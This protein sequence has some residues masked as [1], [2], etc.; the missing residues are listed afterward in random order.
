MICQNHLFAHQSIEESQH[1]AYDPDQPEGNKLPSPTNTER[2]ERALYAL[3]V[4]AELIYGEHRYSNADA[5]TVISDY[6]GDL[7]HL[8]RMNGLH[9]E[10][11]VARARIRHNE[12]CQGD[13]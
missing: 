10:D 8:C 13:I 7:M 5:D 4:Y 11:L 6:L 3:G 1:P 2:G 9:F 12:E